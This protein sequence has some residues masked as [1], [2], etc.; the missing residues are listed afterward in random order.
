M[1]ARPTPLTISVRS[2][3]VRVVA[4]AADV[5][6]V[7]A[8]IAETRADGSVHVT[9]PHGSGR[10]VVRCPAG[11]D[12]TVGTGERRVELVGPFSA[13]RVVTTSGRVD[14]EH[15]GEAEIRATTGRVNVTSCDT[16][17]KVVTRTGRVHV[18][19]A[20]S[21]EIAVVS[22]TVWIG[23]VGDATVQSVSGSITVAG[24]GG[25]HISVRTVTGKVH[26]TVPP[27]GGPALSVR[28]TRGTVRCAVPDGVHG[29]LDVET[30]TG[31]IQVSPR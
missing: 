10:V 18:G 13:V 25:A 3:A 31:S 23:S 26:V 14:V 1:A 8:G 2:G 21:V 19:R 30:T 5:V 27:E 28:S 11:T 6:E 29:V 15:A 20:A 7:D 9:S 4:G 16:A 24:E 17:C 22:G 12:V